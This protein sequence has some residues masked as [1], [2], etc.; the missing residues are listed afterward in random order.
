MVAAYRILV[1]GWPRER[2]VDEMRHGPFGFHEIW[3]GLPRF[4]RELDVERIRA[5]VPAPIVRE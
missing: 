2:A 5:R 3:T 1:Q 4:L